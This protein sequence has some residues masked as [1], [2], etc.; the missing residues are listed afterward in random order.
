MEQT[1]CIIV[2]IA[3][4][5]DLQSEFDKMPG[6]I[7]SKFHGEKHMINKFP[8]KSYLYLG[9]GSRF[10]RRLDKNDQP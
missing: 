7:W 5:F 2:N 8:S 6:F 1:E 10:D 3:W 4:W 9:P